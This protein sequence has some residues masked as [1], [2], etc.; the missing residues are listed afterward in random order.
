MAEETTKSAGQSGPPG[1]DRGRGVPSRRSFVALTVA[2]VVSL[3]A[4]GV[5][6]L[7][8]RWCFA[9][10]SAVRLDPIGLDVFAKDR[11]TPAAADRPVLVLFGDSRAA[12]WVSPDLPEYRVLNRGIGYQTTAQILLRVDAD[13]VSLHPA[14]VVLEAGV[15]DLKAIAEFPER[16]A[17]IVAS[18]EA[19]LRRIV[20]RCHAAGSTVVLVSV[21]RIGDVAAWR[22]PFWSADVDTSVLEVNAFLRTLADATTL[23]LDADP[24]LDDESGRIRQAFQKDHLHL[25]PPA[26]AALDD[27]LVQIVHGLHLFPP[28][29]R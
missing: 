12:M 14:V 4:N 11:A 19:N 3:A 10:T 15:N 26:Y 8:A 24:V 5:L 29:P 2:L 22:R 21:F 17:E 7:V 18:C 28:S 6:V 23:F 20:D 16:R 9:T 1:D 25:V 27:R 13:V